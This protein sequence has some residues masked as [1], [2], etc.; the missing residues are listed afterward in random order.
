MNTIIYKTGDLFEEPTEAIVNT[1]NC[2]GVMGK[3]VALEF[4]QRWP[5]NF[6]A[7][8]K[9]CDAKDMVPGRMFIFD[10]DSLFNNGMHKYLINFPTKQHWRSKSKIEYI[11]DGLVDLVRQLRELKITSVALPQLGCGNGGLEWSE[12][13]PLIEER[14]AELP[15]VKFV[16]VSPEPEN[17][18]LNTTLHRVSLQRPMQRQWSRSQNSEN[19]F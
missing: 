18:G 11:R 17:L 15:D 10:A 8:K 9:R 7:Y 16:V 1:V 19:T 12:V 5:E 13:R 3:G 2:V 6:K 14:L 4:K